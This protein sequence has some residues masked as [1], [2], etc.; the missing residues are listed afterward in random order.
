MYSDA[1]RDPEYM[2]RLKRT[3]HQ[4]YGITAAD[5]VPAKRGYYGETWKIS[6]DAGTY[7]L[8]MD[9]WPFHQGRFRSGLSVLEYLCESGIDFAGKIIKARDGSLCSQF[10]AALMGL[11]EWVD[12]KNVETNETKTPEYQMLCQIYPLTKPGLDIP[13]ASFTD[14]AAVRF[15]RHWEKLKTAPDTEANRAVLA[16]F[17]QFRKEF[18]HCAQRLM[19]FAQRCRR[20]CGDFYLT[21]G[22]AGGNFLIANGKNYIFDWDEAMYAPIERDAWVMGCYAW[23]RQLFNSTLQKNHIPYELR[24]DRLAFYCYHMYFFYL[25]EF[26][27]VHPVCDKSE[28]IADY[29][30]NGWIKGRIEFA[31]T[32]R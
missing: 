5:I 9:Y 27:M 24:P 17:E 2:D 10:D 26:L 29:L 14:D 18:E 8:K 11:F 16:T 15:Y 20:D 22:D 13:T 3:L 21:H 1:L 30:E 32:I 7:F 25:S 4:Q 31:D 6:G 23:A 12:G 19:F 28:R